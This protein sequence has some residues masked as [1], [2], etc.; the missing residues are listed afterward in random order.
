MPAD[1]DK[2]NERTKKT[3]DRGPGR[4]QGSKR[5][6]RPDMALAEELIEYFRCCPSEAQVVWEPIL[7][8]QVDVAAWADRETVLKYFFETTGAL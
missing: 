2:Q 7:Q 4:V 1:D 3:S 6:I 5:S 8:W